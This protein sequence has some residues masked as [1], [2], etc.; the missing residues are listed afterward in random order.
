V[1]IEGSGSI[2]AEQR[3]ILDWNFAADDHLD[4]VK[5]AP[6]VPGKGK[7]GLQIVSGGPDTT[8]KPV[9]E[10][11]VKMIT[12][13]K[14]YVYVQTPYLV[15][16]EAVTAALVTA[17]KSGLDVRVMIPSKPDHPFVYWASL[18]NAGE[19]LNAGVRVHQFNKNGFIHAK[20]VIV[21]DLMASVGSGNLDRRS[22]EL[23]FETNAMVYGPELVANIKSAYIDDIAK[24]C[25]ELTADAYSKRSRKVKIKESIGRLYTPIA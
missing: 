12:S 9:E 5:Y 14:S 15:P 17:A 11:Y 21:D 2:T 7:V 22:F 8:D 23:N 25:I 10:Q 13:A 6:T 3:F 1:R 18:Q 24:N 16:G 19:L 4:L 20:V